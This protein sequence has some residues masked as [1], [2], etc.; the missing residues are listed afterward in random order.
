MEPILCC[1]S[2]SYPVE[3]VPGMSLVTPLDCAGAPGY[4]SNGGS[5]QLVSS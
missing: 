4:R 1:S 5:S 3:T 2:S